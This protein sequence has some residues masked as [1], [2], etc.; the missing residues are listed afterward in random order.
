MKHIQVELE[1]KSHAAKESYENKYQDFL[2]NCR[3]E[4]VTSI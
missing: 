2:S 4:I 3:K 1:Q